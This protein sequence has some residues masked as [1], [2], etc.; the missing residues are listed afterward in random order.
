MILPGNTQV[1]HASIDP[2]PKSLHIS[3]LTQFL[4][5]TPKYQQLHQSRSRIEYLAGNVTHI[6]LCMTECFISSSSSLWPLNE[7]SMKKLRGGCG[8]QKSTP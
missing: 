1:I 4:F 8:G 2:F 3:H 5:D 7:E 6:I